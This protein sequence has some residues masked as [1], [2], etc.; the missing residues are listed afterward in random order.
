MKRRPPPRVIKWWRTT[1]FMVA[2]CPTEICVDIIL[3]WD[4]IIIRIL[5][6]F[7]WCNIHSFFWQFFY[8]HPLMLKY[9]WYWRIEC[10]KLPSFC[11]NFFFLYLF[12]FFISFRPN[13]H[14]HCDILYDPFLYM[15]EHKKIYCMFFPRVSAVPSKSEISIAFTIT[16]Y[17]Y[18]AT[19]PTLWKH[20][21]GL[22]FFSKDR[23]TYWTLFFFFQISLMTILN[24][25]PKTMH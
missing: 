25:S 4:A 19:I 8:K 13:V 14:F 24:I 20:V 23:T 21:M 18:L 6:S 1:S 3:G 10:V 22:I 17:E 7:D 16:M 12:N 2:V 9:R 15:E 5:G 11:H